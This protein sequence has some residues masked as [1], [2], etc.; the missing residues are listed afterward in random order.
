MQMMKNELS[1]CEYNK[2][3]NRFSEIIREENEKT[4]NQNIVDEWLRVVSDFQEKHM[5]RFLKEYHAHIS[6]DPA[7]KIC[8]ELLEY[9]VLSSET[10]NSIFYLELSKKKLFHMVED[11]IWNEI[12]DYLLDVQFIEND[13]CYE[14]N[15]MFAGNYVPKW[16]GWLE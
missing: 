10:G 9:A 14:I 3:M 4:N 6:D 7:K 12:G 1:L 8:F 15:C 13:D 2:I 16:N 11:I 5:D